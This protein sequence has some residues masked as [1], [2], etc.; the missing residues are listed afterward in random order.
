MT[1]RRRPPGRTAVLLATGGAALSAVLGT[2]GFGTLA[3]LLS[4]VPPRGRAMVLLCRWWARL[5]LFC[6]GVRVDAEADP[7]LQRA[8]SY[9]FLSNHQSYF[10]IPALLATIPAE[11][12][13][14]AKRGLFRIPFF[15]WALSA[16]GFIPIDRQNKS[17]ARDAFQVAAGRLRRGGSMLF[18]PEGT[19]SHDG[20]LG[21]FQRGGLLLAIKSGLPLV[22]VGIRGARAVMPR[23]RLRVSPGTITIRYG[24]PIDVT[25]YG[26][27]RRKELME[28]V[29]RQVARLA[30][31]HEGA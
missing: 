24:R 7:G 30:G 22:P 4:W 28:E 9:V 21:P 27:R 29:R 19:R 15:G 3:I 13:F 8:Q 1:G 20:R 23:G 14:A 16:G 17:R 11:A 6:S 31:L 2:V 25:R 18:F 10:D 5:I 26:V 12:R